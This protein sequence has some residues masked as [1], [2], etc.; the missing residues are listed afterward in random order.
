MRVLSLFILLMFSVSL[1]GQTNFEDNQFYVQ[2]NT[3]SEG[4]NTYHSNLLLKGLAKNKQDIPN[5]LSS[6]ETKWE[7]RQEV[8]SLKVDPTGRT[9]TTI[10]HSNV[11]AEE[12]MKLLKMLNPI[13]T[14]ITKM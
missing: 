8:K 11:S 2:E 9:I 6:I 3:P 12:V 13:A 1:W 10:I 4:F 7:A 14:S 5:Y